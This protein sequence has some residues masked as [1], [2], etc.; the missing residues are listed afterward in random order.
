MPAIDTEI[1][2]VHGANQGEKTEEKNRQT[3]EEAFRV[4]D[5]NAE[6]ILPLLT[7]ERNAQIAEVH[8]SRHAG[9]RY[10]AFGGTRFAWY[11]DVFGSIEAE[12]GFGVALNDS[13]EEDEE[14]RH[15][16]LDLVERIVMQRHFDELVPFYELRTDQASGTTMYE[17]I[18]RRVLDTIDAA[19]DGGRKGLVLVGHSMGCAV[20]Y[21]VLTHL[22]CASH[23]R[24]YAQ[25]DG[26][27][28]DE[29]R[30]KVQ[31][32]AA[33]P[34][35]G[36]MTFGNYTG[37]NWCQRLNNRLLFGTPRKQFVYPEILGAWRNYW[38]MNNSDP[39][40]IDDSLEHSIVADDEDRFDD[41][42]V[43]TWPFQ[44]IGHGRANWFARD[45][46]IKK[47]CNQLERHL[48]LEPLS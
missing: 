7:G 43:W 28:S 5:D 41:V 39:Y 36:L 6:R 38:T 46:F 32:L 45:S 3:W 10:P 22:D 34:A 11:G 37:Y 1:V 29:Y 9:C 26:A 48:Y 17:T 15:S 18:C 23:G 20:S 33:I 16:L 24:A 44:N 4:E 14:E 12:S 30:A 40:I 8:K 13:R 21:N 2:F 31:E 27:L 47:L 42:R 25:I 19:T 35:F